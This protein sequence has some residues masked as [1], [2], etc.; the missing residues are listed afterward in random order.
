MSTP[1]IEPESSERESESLTTWAKIPANHVQHED[2]KE[3][4]LLRAHNKV[5]PFGHGKQ[6]KYQNKKMIAVGFE[7]TTSALRVEN[8]NG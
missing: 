2:I 3:Y 6:K 1:G 4:N 7:P 8:V 5:F